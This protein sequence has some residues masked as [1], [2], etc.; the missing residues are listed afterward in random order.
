MWV[1]GS[2]GLAPLVWRGMV[3]HGVVL[4]VAEGV[5]DGV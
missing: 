1:G 3:W 5:G 4:R 2:D